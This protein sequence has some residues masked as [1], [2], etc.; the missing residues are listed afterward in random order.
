MP[1]AIR[2]SD[3]AARKRAQVKL[4]LRTA[5]SVASAAPTAPASVGVKMP[6]KSPAK[7]PIMV[8]TMGQVSRSAA[9]FSRLVAV[10]S[11]GGASDGLRR[12]RTMTRMT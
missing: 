2:V 11:A 7:M 3:T 9:I 6:P 1:V 4:R 8:A 10:T 12:T 5:T